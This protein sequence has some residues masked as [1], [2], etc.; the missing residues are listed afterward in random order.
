MSSEPEAVRAHGE[1]AELRSSQPAGLWILAG[2]ELW[3]RIAF[4]GVQALLVLYMTDRLLLPGR[5][6]HIV[7]FAGLRAAVESLTGPLPVMAL[8]AQTFGLYVGLTYLAPAIGGAIGDRLIDRHAAVTLGAMLIAAGD[9]TLVSDDCFLIALA[10]L[11]AGSGLLRGN[12]VPQVRVLYADEDARGPDAF[13]LY[14]AAINSGAFVAPIVTGV[15]AVCCGIRACFVFAG[16]GMLVGLTIYLVG[17]R[18]LSSNAAR[19]EKIGHGALGAGDRRRLVGIAMLWSV[20]VL[21]WIAQTQIWNVY[22][23]WVRDHVL[24]AI[25]SFRV[26]VP[27]LQALDGLAPLLLLPPLLGLWRRQ[28]ARGREPD[29]IAK[30]AIGCAIA[31]CGMIILAAAPI[32][33]NTGGRV[34]IVWPVLFHLVSNV[35]WLYFAPVAMALYAATAPAALRGTLLGINGLAIFVASI[36]SGR[37]GGLY[38]SMT[39]TRFWLIHAAIVGSSG[40]ILLA[41]ARPLRHLLAVPDEGGLRVRKP[42]RR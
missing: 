38:A 31:A 20:Q 41:L 5:V 18:H 17:M 11:I 23:I 28:R 15:L 8:A 27:W 16:C 2:T 36:G 25:G 9:F 34:S 32:A 12:L 4:H 37:F 6:E 13:Q 10:L 40:A 22:N 42:S 35:G 39:P 26:P 33:A 24:L 30:M 7:G 21:F 19:V 1:P 14:Y 3:D 29:E